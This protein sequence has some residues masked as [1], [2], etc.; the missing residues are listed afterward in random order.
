MLTGKEG[1]FDLQKSS[2]EVKVGL[3]GMLKGGVIVDVTT[4]EEARMAEEAGAISVLAV[5]SSKDLSYPDRMI[6]PEAIQ[7][8][9]EAV[10]IPVMVECCIGHT[11]E[12]QILEA[13]FVD[14]IGE[15]EKLTSVDETHH[16]DK[17][18]FRIPFFSSARNLAECLKRVAEGASLIRTYTPK[19]QL[20]LAQIVGQLRAIRRE[21]KWLA[22]LDSQDLL[23]EVERMGVPYR[24]IK[25]VSQTGELPVPLFAS[26][27]VL[28]A[29]DAA[30]VVRLGAQSLFIDS[31][32]FKNSN[33][34]KA[35]CSIVS[36]VNHANNPE[37]LAKIAMG[38]FCDIDKTLRL[39]SR[40][41]SI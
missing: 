35:L 21:I 40:D 23:G 13:L 16:I 2:F 41:Q 34:L 22:S 32:I 1:S 39:L 3:A 7:R 5:S 33:P 12:A 8:I 24:L 26:Y 15:S 9:Q 28:N 6:N 18:A 20:N 4:A 27:G 17:H 19:G 25:Q 38:K 37:I 36:A 11:V 10:S 29:A 31:E 14:F 30:L